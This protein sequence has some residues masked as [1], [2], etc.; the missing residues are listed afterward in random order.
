[1]WSQDIGSTVRN[2]KHF[3]FE[4]PSMSISLLGLQKK[5]S[6]TM[7]QVQNC[8]EPLLRTTRKTCTILGI[9]DRNELE[10]KLYPNQVFTARKRSLGQGNIFTPVCHS[11]HR[12][13][14]LGRYPLG[15]YPPPNRY[16]L[17]RYPQAGTPPWAGTPWQIHPLGW[18]TPRQVHPPKA[19]IPP[20][21]YPR[22]EV[23]PW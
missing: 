13:E 16:P 20:D 15:R 23:P 2:V 19:G 22:T 18:Y 10:F 21:K 7:S 9:E 8:H 17:G 5:L 6:K 11:V 1:M 14:Y 3:I 12:G 4:V